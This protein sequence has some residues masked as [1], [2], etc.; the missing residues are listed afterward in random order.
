M[1]TIREILDDADPLRGESRGGEEARARTR[2][3]VLAAA[4]RATSS[5]TA[6]FGGFRIR[7]AVTAVVVVAAAAIVVLGARTWSAGGTT[8]HAAAIRLE[9]RLAETQPTI[10]L[11]AVRV[12]DSGATIYLH[13]EVIVTN[14]DIAG[15]G[16]VAGSDAQHFGVNVAFT[17]AG[18]EQMRRATAAHIGAPLAI[19]IDGD[20]IS[21][22]TLR[23]PIADAAVIS[24]DFTRAEAERIAEG[25]RI[26]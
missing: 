6:R 26:R 20:V 23:S 5:P 10:G 4:A 19:L 16:V 7:T 15:S 24:G 17:A 9:V 12:A 1:K 2:R 3:A 21:A 8:L 11:P 25:M 18:A 13:P 14:E 22:P